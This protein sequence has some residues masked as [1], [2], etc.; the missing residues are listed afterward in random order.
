MNVAP[1]TLA[2]LA[3]L[4]LWGAVLVGSACQSVPEPP[5]RNVEV[6]YSGQLEEV[7]P[8]DVVIPEIIDQ[9]VDGNVPHLELRQ[10]FQRSLID[11]RYSALALPYVDRRV[12]NA[13]YQAGAR[14]EDAILQITVREWDRTRY[15]STGELHVRIEAW[16]LSAEDQTELWGGKLERTLYLADEMKD[17]PTEKGALAGVAQRLATELL[18]MMP[19]RNPRP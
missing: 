15:D 2:S 18:E 5:G 16:M 17:Q 11:R 10:A 4:A 9:S 1:R 8:M 19:A 13:T 14:N 7:Q 12:V 3:P 6:L